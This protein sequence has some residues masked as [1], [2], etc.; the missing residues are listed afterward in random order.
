VTLKSRLSELNSAAL[1]AG[2]VAFALYIFLGLPV[3]LT[4]FRE[5]G[6]TAAESSSWLLITWLTMGIASLA[7]AF[8]LRQP[9][10]ITL[11]IP[12][13][14]YLGTLGT[15]Y[16]FGQL[17]LANLLAGIVIL[18]LGIGGV[19]ERVLRWFPTPI[20]MGMFAGTIISFAT[21]LVGATVNDVWIAG[22]AVGAYLLGRAIG[23]PRLPPSGSERLPASSRWP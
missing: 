6:L 23:N 19:V 11:T 13:I 10:S 8:F 17:A 15:Q 4:A 18:G 9:V 7:V 12:G 20:V 3:Q 5:L 16:S 14:I 2:L 22:P 1:S 21:R